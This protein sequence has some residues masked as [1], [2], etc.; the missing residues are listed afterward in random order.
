MNENTEITTENKTKYKKNRKPNNS[1]KVTDEM[2]L[3]K[4]ADAGI[5]HIYL[6]GVNKDKNGNKVYHFDKNSEIKEIIDK[7]KETGVI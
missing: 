5:L 6:H 1:Y 2:L 7:F 3:Y 4:I